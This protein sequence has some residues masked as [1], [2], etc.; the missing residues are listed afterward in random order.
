MNIGYKNKIATTSVDMREKGRQ[1]TTGGFMWEKLSRLS[2][3]GLRKAWVAFM[4]HSTLTV[5]Q[6]GAYC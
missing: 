3:W 2:L 6:W 1:K 5:M 4:E